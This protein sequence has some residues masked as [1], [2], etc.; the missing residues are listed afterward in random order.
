MARAAAGEEITITD[1]GRPVA[2]ISGLEASAVERLIGAGLARPAL[3]GLIDLPAPVVV[4]DLVRAR[5]DARRGTLLTFYADTSALVKLAVVEAESAAMRAWML[6]GTVALAS[7]DLART[8]LLRAVRRGAPGAVGAARDV[9]SRLLLITASA[10]IFDQATRLVPV[11]LRSLDA[12]H[13]ARRS[14]WVTI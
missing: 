3:Q 10:E 2:R 7:S 11:E 9:L 8:E 1:R 13:L 14:R 5:T 4:A 6:T 12:V